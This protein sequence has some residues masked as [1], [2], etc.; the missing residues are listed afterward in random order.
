MYRGLSLC[1]TTPCVK[2]LTTGKRGVQSGK[3]RYSVFERLYS[4]AW[5]RE[6]KSSKPYQFLADVVYFFLII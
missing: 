1:D 3:Q 5:S 6:Y 2:F 4:G